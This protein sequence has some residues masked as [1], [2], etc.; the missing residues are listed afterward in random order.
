MLL[1][2]TYYIITT[3]TLSGIITLGTITVKIFSALNSL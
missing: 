3:S 2:T 1:E